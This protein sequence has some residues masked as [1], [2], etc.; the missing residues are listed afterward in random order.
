MPRDYGSVINVTWQDPLHYGG[1]HSLSYILERK[2]LR[3]NADVCQ[4]D[5][6]FSGYTD[7]KKL[8]G[9]S[10]QYSTLDQAQISTWARRTF[11]N[12]ETG[13]KQVFRSNETMNTYFEEVLTEDALLSDSQATFFLYR[14]RADSFAGAGKISP[15]L[16]K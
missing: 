11:A 4:L 14:V 15:L 1:V 8:S 13:Y 12:S 2:I 6:S 3:R 9:F 5:G 7:V 16:F 10:T